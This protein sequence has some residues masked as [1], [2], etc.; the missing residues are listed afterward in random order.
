MHYLLIYELADDYLERRGGFRAAHMALAWQ[1]QER[2]EVLLGGVLTAP[3]DSAILLFQGDS[4]RV[5]EAFRPGLPFRAP[6][7]RSPAHRTGC[8]S[9]ATVP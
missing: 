7:T 5:A 4:P 8:A 6:P 3:V 9:G 2:G 1:A